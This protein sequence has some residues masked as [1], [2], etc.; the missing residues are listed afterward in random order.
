MS[1]GDNTTPSLT[2][3]KTKVSL[4]FETF[5]RT[6]E[7]V[8]EI[9]SILLQQQTSKYTLLRIL[10]SDCLSRD[11]T[12]Y[13]GV[14]FCH[15][16][17]R[18]SD[19]AGYS[20][21]SL[22]SH[23]RSRRTG[24]N[25]SPEFET[26]Y[27]KRRRTVHPNRVE[28]T[29]AV[30]Y[31]LPSQN[32]GTNFL[33]ND[34]VET[35]TSGTLPSASY[36]RAQS[37]GSGSYGSVVAVYN[38]DG[39][40]YALKLFLDDEDDDDEDDNDNLDI[41]MNLGALREISILRLFRH[42][43]KHPNIVELVDIKEGFGE[44]DDGGGTSGVLAIAMPLY[45]DGTLGNAINK[46]LLHSRTLKIR[47]AHG[48]LCGIV[49]LHD[50]G[51][52]HR[53]IKADNIMVVREDDGTLKPVLIDFSL[54]KLVNGS[55]YNNISFVSDGEN[56]PTHTGQVGSATYTAPEILADESYSLKA[57]LWSVGVIFLELLQNHTLVAEKNKEAERRIAEAM[58]TLPDQPFANLIRNLLKVNPRQRFSA[59]Q[60]LQ[61]PL[62][63]K[64]NLSIPPVKLLD[65]ETAL[66]IEKD[67]GE[68][69]SQSEGQNR[70]T[71]TNL[72]S[73]LERR[74]K[75]IQRIC[76]EIG[77]EHPM[78]VLTAMCYSE[79][80]FQLDDEI[81]N[82]NRSQ[83]LLDCILL[84]SKYWDTEIPNFHDLEGTGS[85]CKWTIG[86]Y[87]DTEATIWMLMDY[88]LLPRGL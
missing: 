23:L 3:G 61:S 34:I 27:K 71:F 80:L 36:H 5:I 88:C 62:F 19:T 9:P 8:P 11:S 1:L 30:L 51:V 37:L 67:T 52:I 42:N 47:I 66:P 64:F 82:Q 46:G 33:T 54:A 81:D 55:L 29:L 22:S 18:P 14:S 44:G 74:T 45:G 2:D 60:A 6:H 16:I 53:D 57:D 38:D 17:L 72:D 28:S 41:G 49:H 87:E 70:S 69:S 59:R 39:E 12:V 75:A 65:I 7:L 21:I 26:R 48:I 63:R 35:M 20:R 32:N 86:E 78:T 13:S 68:Q 56:E 79:I 4:R 83:G 73:I 43:N 24:S 76:H 25:T 31:L 85:F 15:M 40:E 77:A 10:L 84:A 50:N 58:Q